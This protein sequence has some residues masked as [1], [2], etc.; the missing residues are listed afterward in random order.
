MGEL[1]F[2]TLP[3]SKERTFK[4]IGADRGRQ[5]ASADVAF[6]DRDMVVRVAVASGHV[7]PA[8]RAELMARVFELAA[9]QRSLTGVRACLPS[10]DPD[11]LFAM[12]SY[13]HDVHSH[14]AGSTCLVE[15]VIGPP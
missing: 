14:A 6:T 11:L 2:V 7:Q 1:E 4:I 8:A 3:A 12:D 9:R 15:A 13:C 10:G 5:F